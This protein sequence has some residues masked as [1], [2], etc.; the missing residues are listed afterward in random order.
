MHCRLTPK[1]S[2][3]GALRNRP[4]W[5]GTHEPADTG[6]HALCCC[7]SG[8]RYWHAM[9]EAWPSSGWKKWGAGVTHAP[10][11]AASFSPCSPRHLTHSRAL[12]LAHGVCPQQPTSL[13]TSIHANHPYRARS[14]VLASR[15]SLS[16]SLPPSLSPLS[17]SLSLSLR[18]ISSTCSAQPHRTDSTPPPSA[19]SASPASPPPPSSAAAP[20]LA[21]P[22]QS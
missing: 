13:K 4:G 9:A 12:A 6:P 1:A 19:Q 14:P 3:G 18:S 22:V 8:H 10:V 20:S 21:P 11:P 17:L 2:V 16:L 7:P 15:L 5:Q